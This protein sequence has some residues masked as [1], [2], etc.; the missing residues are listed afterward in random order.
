[1]PSKVSLSASKWLKF[2]S[3]TKAMKSLSSSPAINAG[4]EALL[5]ALSLQWHTGKPFAVCEAMT[6][7]RLGSP[8]TLHRRISRLKALGLIEDKSNPE[9]LRIKLL[10]PTQRAVSYF[11]KMGAALRKSLEPS[12]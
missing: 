2:L 5:N 7:G 6:L 1:M 3:L 10:V 12:A 11:E 9:N 8:S 4:D